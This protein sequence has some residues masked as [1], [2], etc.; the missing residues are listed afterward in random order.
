M[1]TFQGKFYNSFLLRSFKYLTSFLVVHIVFMFIMAA[2]LC[3]VSL[4]SLHELQFCMSDNS[5]A[6]DSREFF[7]L[8]STV[9][10]SQFLSYF[11]FLSKLIFRP[12]SFCTLNPAIMIACSIRSR[13]ESAVLVAVKLPAT[14]VGNVPVTTP[15]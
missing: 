15:G 3:L 5:A 13:R 4:K 6:F 8:N 11:A 10:S 14:N 7:Q 9:S 12:T 2:L 1:T